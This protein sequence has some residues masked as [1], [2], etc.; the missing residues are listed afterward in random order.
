MIDGDND[1]YEDQH[2]QDDVVV[3]ASAFRDV[4]DDLPDKDQYEEEKFER[5][6]DEND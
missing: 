3:H 2:D 1:H 5:D 4:S 6:V